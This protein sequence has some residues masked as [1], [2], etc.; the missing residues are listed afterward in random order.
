[1]FVFLFASLGSVL[2]RRLALKFE[3]GLDLPEG[4]PEVAGNGLEPGGRC[5]GGGGCVAPGVA[6][7]WR[8][9]VVGAGVVLR[10]GVVDVDGRVPP[11][12]TVGTSG[13]VLSPA[14]PCR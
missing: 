12:R 6:G 4:R 10:T 13:T 14:A 11:G 2:V 5:G 3:I 9:G 8:D 7:D 1:M